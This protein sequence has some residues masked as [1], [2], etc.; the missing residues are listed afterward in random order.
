MI[1]IL[2]VEQGCRL[3]VALTAVEDATRGYCVGP[4]GHSLMEQGSLV[5]AFGSNHW[6]T[7]RCWSPESLP[8][9]IRDRV[10]K[11]PKVLMVLMIFKVLTLL[12]VQ[13]VLR[14]LIE[15]IPNDVS[16]STRC[17]RRR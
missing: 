17:A 15:S 3:R 1:S 7:V 5:C 11:V 8:T 4:V 14:V 2:R 12:G 13:R 6:S 10:L 16:Q 9:R